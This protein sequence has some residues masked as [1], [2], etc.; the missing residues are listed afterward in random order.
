MFPIHDQF[1]SL[2]L[3]MPGEQLMNFCQRVPKEWPSVKQDSQ[4]YYALSYISGMDTGSCVL[5]TV[6]SLGEREA[7]STLVWWE[8]SGLGPGDL[9]PLTFCDSEIFM[10]QPG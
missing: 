3:L 8:V 9:Y 10:I 2:F 5:E 7:L 4:N 1:C 6:L